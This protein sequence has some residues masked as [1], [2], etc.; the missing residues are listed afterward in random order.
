MNTYNKYN[1][2]RVDRAPIIDKIKKK[3][4]EHEN[5]YNALVIYMNNLKDDTLGAFESQ[6]NELCLRGR[7]GLLNNKLAGMTLDG[8]KPDAYILVRNSQLIVDFSYHYLLRIVFEKYKKKIETVLLETDAL[9]AIESIDPINQTVTFNAEKYTEVFLNNNSFALDKC[10]GCL[11]ICR[12]L[13]TRETSVVLYRVGDLRAAGSAHTGS[14][15]TLS[16]GSDAV[17]HKNIMMIR[18]TAI[19]MFIRDNF[20]DLREM[21]DIDYP[22]SIEEESREIEEPQPQENKEPSETVKEFAQMIQGAETMDDLNAVSD[23]IKKAGLTSAERAS[24]IPLFTE[25]KQVLS[26]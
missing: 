14:S 26:A 1:A 16:A 8:I 2:T 25:R 24:L 6:F 20:T 21:P 10:A 12:D 13:D 17:K 5:L 4:G 18:K 22:E 15:F 23:Q 9:K 11:V 19:R 7:V 3:L